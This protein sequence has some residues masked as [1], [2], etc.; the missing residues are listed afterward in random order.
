M[1]TNRYLII[2]SSS[3]ST[4][5]ALRFSL[6]RSIVWLLGMMVV[7]LVAYGILGSFKYREE[8]EIHLRYLELQRE[9]AALAEANQVIPQIRQKEV[10]IRKFLG[11]EPGSG[12]SGV[13]GQGGR[14]PGSVRVMG[15]PPEAENVQSRT[16]PADVAGSPVSPYQKAA[17]LDLDLQELV[18]FLEK[19][20]SDFAKLPTI[21]PLEIPDPWISC[22][23]GYRKSPFTGLR[24]FHSGIDLS[25]PRGTP[26]IAPADGVVIF[27]GQDRF[28]GKAIRIKHSSQY[29]TVYGH[30][31]DF[32]V[33]VNQKVARG[34]IIGYV[35]KTGRSTGYHLHYEIYRD[36][37]AINP[38]PC[39]LNLKR[40]ELLLAKDSASQ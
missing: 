23:F 22:H 17:L 6:H 7:V 19:Q 21:C 11:L 5:P 36:R 16:A 1:R 14:R 3:S 32:H 25:A 38:F 8:S 27:I 35:G 37:M 31:L 20:Q 4:K 15:V 10:M 9:K 39:L 28:L 34:D 29:E 12:T 24:E 13:P 33:K 18:D 26:I 40:Q 2:I 30:L